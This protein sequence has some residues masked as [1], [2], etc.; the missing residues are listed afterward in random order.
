M[1]D[2]ALHIPV[3]LPEVL[4]VL[5]VEEEGVYVDATFGAGGYSRALLERDPTVHV[6]AIDRDP[7]V[8]SHAHALSVQYGKRRLHF[9]SGRFGMMD[10]LVARAGFTHITGVVL[11]VGVSSMQIDDAQR[12]FSFMKSGPLDMRMEQ[13]GLSAA[14]VVN[15]FEEEKS[16]ISFTTLGR[17]PCASCGAGDYSGTSACGAF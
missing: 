6:I 5:A 8:I 14:D 15:T 17:A 1:T 10:E 4:D 2:T 11:D 13:S 9:L 3:M 7:G 12:G 16:Q